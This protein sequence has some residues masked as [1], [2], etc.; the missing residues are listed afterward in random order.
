MFRVMMG[1]FGVLGCIMAIGPV[2]LA[3]VLAARG[4]DASQFLGAFMGVPFGIVVCAVCFWLVRRHG[5]VIKRFRQPVVLRPDGFVVAGVGPVPWGAVTP[6]QKQW[7]QARYSDG[8]KKQWA[9]WFA[10]G[11]GE[12]IP[13][14]FSPE[15]RKHALGGPGPVWARRYEYIWLPKVQEL[16]DDAMG[17]LMYQAWHQFMGQQPPPRR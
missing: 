13:M 7:M 8:N 11:A 1:V 6:P 16:D 12:V 2:V 17:Q 15:V 4:G 9:M 10:P 3:I 14:W 5:R